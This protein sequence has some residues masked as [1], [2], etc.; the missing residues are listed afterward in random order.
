MISKDM[1]HIPVFLEICIENLNI[2]PDG[3]YLD[4]TLG[5]GGHAG[6]IAEKLDSGKLIAID[7]DAAAI[8]ESKKRLAKYEGRITYIHANFRHIAAILDE[9]DIDAVDG[10]LFDLGVSSPQLDDAGR[11][12]S[13][14]KDAMLDMRMDKREALTAYDIV[15]GW[16]EEELRRIFG[17][18]GEERYSGRIAHAIVKRRAEEKIKTTFDLNSVILSAIPPAARREQ[19]H[20]SKRCYQSLRYACN[21]EI[22]SIDDMLKSA[23]DRL[24]PG[25][26]IC[27]I[28]FESISDRRVKNAFSS[29]ING[30]VCPKGLPVCACGFVPTLRLVAKKPIVPDEA[31]LRNPRSRSAKLRVAERV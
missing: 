16:S 14:M 9:L 1:E 25:G 4:G 28:S 11:G 24:K 21:E 3:T 10:M 27:V 26:R 20:P 22:E 17:E 5:L 23:P 18:Y 19:Q 31:E 2:K 8:E 12:F 6:K 15:N 13:Y 29:R 7:R 30:C